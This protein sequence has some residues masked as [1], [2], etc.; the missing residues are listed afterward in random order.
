MATTEKFSIV[1]T[2]E[3]VIA[4]KAR[5][6]QSLDDPRPNLTSRQMRE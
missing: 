1:L 4:I 3:M 6:Q 5:V 2:P